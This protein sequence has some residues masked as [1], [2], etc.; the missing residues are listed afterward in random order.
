MQR[1]S[2]GFVTASGDE[3]QGNV[4][5]KCKLAASGHVLTDRIKVSR[6]PSRGVHVHVIK[7][8]I[9][10]FISQRQSR[11]TPAGPA[12]TVCASAFIMFDGTDILYLFTACFAAGIWLVFNRYQSVRNRAIPFSWPAPEV[13]FSRCGNCAHRFNIHFHRQQ[14]RT[15]PH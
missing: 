7:T 6:F 5:G 11:T 8:L 9:S 2:A 10:N 4:F 12:H 13:R 3:R 14:I 1:R 15:G